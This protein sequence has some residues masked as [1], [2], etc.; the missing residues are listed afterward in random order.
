MEA[1]ILY[2][3]LFFPG[4]FAAP[5][6]GGNL[7]VISF[8]IIRELS[9]ILVYILPALALIWYLILK[10]KSLAAYGPPPLKVEKRD[11]I[12]FAAVLP[13][14]ISIALFVNL[15][16]SLFSQN[17]GLP[18]PPALEGPVNTLGWIVLVIG[19][20]GTGYLEE[21]YF[22]YYLLTKLEK[23]IPQTV[24]RVIFATALFAICHM[25][26]GPWAVLNAALA[27]LFLSAVFIRF[28]SLHGIAWAHAAYNFFVFVTMG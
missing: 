19:C 27:G 22:R 16:I 21:T 18:P 2:F 6:T 15:L 12:I 24:L 10:K 1:L 28:R 7:E 9:R 4:T 23:L 26:K 3:V 11:L 5:V 8:S 20:L 13:G 17:L 25:Y 14:I